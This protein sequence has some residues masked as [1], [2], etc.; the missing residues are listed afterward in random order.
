MKQN[1]SCFAVDLN[2]DKELIDSYEAYHQIGNIWPEIT[3]GIRASG[4]LV[5]EIYRVENR[6]F[7]IVETAN[8]ISIEAAFEQF[9]LL[10][11]QGEW[12]TLM[13]TFQSRL[14][15]ARH[16]EQWTKMNLIFSLDDSAV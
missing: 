13:S 11:R 5:M 14:A 3:E 7:M 12:L 9:N 4:I 8:E 6:L 15:T 2:N 16:G 1:R 10:P